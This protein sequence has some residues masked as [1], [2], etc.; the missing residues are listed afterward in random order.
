MIDDSPD[1]RLP[2]DRSMLVTKKIEGFKH[3]NEWHKD[4]RQ[5]MTKT[6][7]LLHKIFQVYQRKNQRNESRLNFVR[8][9]FNSYL[10]DLGKF[11]SHQID[12]SNKAIHSFDVKDPQSMPIFEQGIYEML[13]AIKNNDKKVHDLK[14]TFDKMVT[15]PMN[16]SIGKHV[17]YYALIEKISK[18]IETFTELF[19]RS[20]KEYAAVTDT[21]NHSMDVKKKKQDKDFYF[22]VYKC[23]TSIRQI[24]STLKSFS[25]DITK[26]R[27]LAV[28]KENEYLKAFSYAFKQFGLFSQDNFGNIITSTLSRSKFI[29]E[30]IDGKYSVD[31]DYVMSKM[32]PADDSEFHGVS[33][34]LSNLSTVLFNHI[35][36]M[37]VD[38]IFVVFRC[39]S[40]IALGSFFSSLVACDLCIS[41]DGFILIHTD[42][43]V[44]VHE[45]INVFRDD[46]LVNDKTI[47]LQYV[48][49][50]VLF[51]SNK[52]VRLVF[53]DEQTMKAFVQSFKD[54]HAVYNK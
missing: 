29:F 4:N 2:Y 49:K 5:Q 25:E 9:Y 27:P 26:L 44:A 7:E 42:S 34:D 50:G 14:K 19:E 31:N 35:C 46:M 33:E 36:D 48:K 15:E 18:H 43:K 11:A 12:F 32:V 10:E 28:N 53:S 38:H 16:K 8:A 24:Y 22:E 47:T 13:L 37:S 1:D 45:K 17:E 54:I 39:V 6:K 52:E 3:L 51:D 41:I 40:K 30:G 20:T 21:F 23:V